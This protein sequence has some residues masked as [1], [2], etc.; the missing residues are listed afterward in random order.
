MPTPRRPG[1]RRRGRATMSSRTCLP[2]PPGQGRRHARAV[3]RRHEPGL[4][5]RPHARVSVARRLTASD[6][7]ACGACCGPVG[8]R[9]ACG[10]LA[11]ACSR[12]SVCRSA[13]GCGLC[14][15]GRARRRAAARCQLRRPSRQWPASADRDS[16]PMAPSNPPTNYKNGPA[17]AMQGRPH[18]R[19]A[20]TEALFKGRRTNRDVACCVGLSNGGVHS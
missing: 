8:G 6:V 18:R 10:L 13:S 4:P 12:K 11:C 1:P 20:P 15:L 16:P 14:D 17:H 3:G 9:W 7:C 5:C 19:G 2:G